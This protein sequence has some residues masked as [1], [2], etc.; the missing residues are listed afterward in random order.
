M[1]TYTSQADDLYQEANEIEYPD[2]F[3]PYT[4]CCESLL[5]IEEIITRA[6]EMES[7]AREMESAA[8]DIQKK[9]Q[10]IAAF[11]LPI[12]TSSLLRKAIISVKRGKV[13]F[14]MDQ[15]VQ[16][17][18]VM[19]ENLPYIL[20]CPKSE[21]KEYV[22]LLFWSTSMDDA[23]CEVQKKMEVIKQEIA[24]DQ[25]QLSC[26]VENVPAARRQ[27]L[28]LLNNYTFL[29]VQKDDVCHLPPDNHEQLETFVK[30]LTEPEPR[31]KRK[32]D[33]ITSTP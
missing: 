29:K 32:V 1:E 25:F 2:Y 27:F 16:V 19:M 7:A 30:L 28:Y 24:V 31:K 8:R 13:M 10:E 14:S 17:V 3:P 12:P 11:G 5:E 33:F 22:V 15:L 20:F 4:S 9:F 23:A 21:T 26:V 6:R 18:D